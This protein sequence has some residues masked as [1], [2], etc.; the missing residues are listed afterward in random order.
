MSGNKLFLK[1][2]FK[3]K[4]AVFGLIVLI[5]FIVVAILAPYITPYDFQEGDYFLRLKGPCKEHPLGLDSRGRDL[6]SG[7]ILGSRIS[8]KVGFAVIIISSVVGT[9]IG[10]FSGY[11]G[12]IFDEIIMRIVDIFLAFPGILLAIALTSILGRGI[13]HVIL[14]LCIMGWVSFARLAR[15]QVLYVKEKEYIEAVKALGA[16]PIRIMFRHI[17]PNIYA[18]ILVQATL[19]IAGAI[20]AESGL[21]FLGLGAKIGEPSWGNILQ[22]GTSYLREAPHIATFSGLVIML[23]VLSINFVGDALR[24]AFDPKMKIEYKF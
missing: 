18:P 1:K 19:G 24:D 6:L 11:Y 5:I 4:L 17:L 7:L 2:F 12:G 10:I 14:A 9:L 23:I 13:N 3:N 8:L 22:D 15:A 20:I 16:S 21:S